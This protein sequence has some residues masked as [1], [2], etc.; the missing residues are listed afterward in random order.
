MPEKRSK[1]DTDPLDPEFARQSEEAWGGAGTSPVNDAPTE[2][3]GGATRP[4]GP[5][6]SQNERARL[7]PEADAPTRRIDGRF[8]QSY[9]SV[10]VPPAYEPPRA[11]LYQQ[12]AQPLQPQVRPFAGAP[13]GRNVAGINVPERYAHAAPY[14]PFYIG[15][16]VSVIE[17][18]VVPRTE[19][20]TRF[21]AAQGLALH[22]CIIAVNLAL[23]L[24][25]TIVGTRFGGFV[26]SVAALAFL[27]YS[28][29]RVWQGREH[30][31]APLADATRWL[32]EKIDP[33][34]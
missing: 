17:L 20:R 19:V 3:F 33:R 2:L 16:V 1:Y 26:F 31:V 18:L 27:V 8:G 32:D 12:P 22:L 28:L 30:R 25:G 14:A 23:G 5:P 13:A 11:P 24:V 34:K 9:P 4:V 10:F 6:A 29:I 21:H 7:N 15:L